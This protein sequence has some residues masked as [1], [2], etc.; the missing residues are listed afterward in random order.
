MALYELCPSRSWLSSRI[1]LYDYPLT[2]GRIKCEYCLIVQ[3]PPKSWR[4]KI[5]RRI[6]FSA[7]SAKSCVGSPI[8]NMREMVFWSVRIGI[9][10]GCAVPA[11]VIETRLDFIATCV[12]KR[13]SVTLS[14]VIFYVGVYT[15]MY[16]TY[17]SI[18]VTVY[19]PCI[20][21]NKYFL[22]FLYLNF[23]K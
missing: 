10:H 11:S 3:S 13:R 17:R 23:I 19:I 8:F 21:N 7:L 5:Y 1:V 16:Y 20:T 14:R 22:Y 12:R 4:R 6:R 9:D 18:C 2:F 15:V